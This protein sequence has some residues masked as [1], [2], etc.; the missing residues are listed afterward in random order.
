MKTNQKDATK[1]SSAEEKEADRIGKLIH[2]CRK[3]RGWSQ[4][5]L[6][7]Q[8]N[9]FEGGE[10]VYRQLISSFEC[11]DRL[12]TI[13]QLKAIGAALEQNVREWL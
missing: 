8:V 1:N 7:D 6:T 3:L 2:E 5:Y 12:P 4:Q 13:C 11:G 10:G 9:K